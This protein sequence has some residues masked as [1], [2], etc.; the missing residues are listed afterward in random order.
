QDAGCQR[1]DAQLGV[2]ESRNGPARPL[3][4]AKPRWSGRRAQWSAASKTSSPWLWV[5]IRRG[6]SSSGQIMYRPFFQPGAIAATAMSGIEQACW[7]ILGKS[8]GAPVYMLLGGRVRDRLRM[9]NHLGGGEMKAVYET[10]GVEPLLERSARRALT[11]SRSRNL[12]AE[13]K[14]TR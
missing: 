6:S 11:G 7:D 3:D 9:Y 10:P 14:S 12:V 2:C 5:K 1:R 8:L 4:G 13:W